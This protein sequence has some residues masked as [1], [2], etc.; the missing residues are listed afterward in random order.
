[1]GRR[2]LQLKI[3]VYYIPMRKTEIAEISCALQRAS[4]IAKQATAAVIKCSAQ[5]SARVCKDERALLE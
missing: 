5:K 2:A 1:L 4:L 3:L